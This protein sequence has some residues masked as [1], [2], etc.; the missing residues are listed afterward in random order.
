MQRVKF[1]LDRIVEKIT[2]AQSNLNIMRHNEFQ[3]TWL[4]QVVTEL[5]LEKKKLQHALSLMKRK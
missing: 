3:A 5:D 1:R 2:I 4:R